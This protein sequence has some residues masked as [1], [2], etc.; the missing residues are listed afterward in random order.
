MVSIVLSFFQ[1]AGSFMYKLIVM[2]VS[3]RSMDGLE[4]QPYPQ[5]LLVAIS[6]CQCIHLRGIQQLNK[7]ENTC[8]QPFQ[9]L[10]FP[11]AKPQVMKSFWQPQNVLNIRCRCWAGMCDT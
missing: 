10:Q 11:I 6:F 3:A 2:D 5:Y 8:I 4:K 1:A 7:Y 9:P